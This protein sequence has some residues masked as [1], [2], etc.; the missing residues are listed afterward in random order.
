[1]TAVRLVL[2]SDRVAAGERAD[3]TAE[4]VRAILEAAGLELEGVVAVPDDEAALVKAL[5]EAV[6]ACP[7]VLTSGG[8]GLSV[9]DVTPEA[10]RRVLEREIPGLGEAMRAASRAA[11]PTADLSRGLAG[12]AGQS[13]LINLPGSPAGA[14]ECLEAVLPAVLHGLRILK[15]AVQDC[16]DDLP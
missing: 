1:V 14:R 10:T 7:L 13:L 4:G 5:R 6:A 11:V 3:A 15:G 2:A 16:A 8:T 12:T 9:R